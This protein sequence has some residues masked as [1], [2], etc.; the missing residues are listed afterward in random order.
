MEIPLQTPKPQPLFH[1]VG[2]T[3]GTSWTARRKVYDSS[4]GQHI[5]DFRHHNFDIKN[6]WVA[7]TPTGRKLCS[8]EDKSQTTKHF[9]LDTT[10]YTESG[11]EV[12]VL[13][14]SNDPWPLT[15]TISV[16]GTDIATIGKA[17]D[18][19]TY[20]REKQDRSVWTARVASGVDLSLV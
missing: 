12:L 18:N 1:V 7:E 17:E 6:G 20:G 19:P 9:A 2:K 15:V 14:R 16:G 5:F 10:V 3:L 11:E 13:M 8:L 4:N